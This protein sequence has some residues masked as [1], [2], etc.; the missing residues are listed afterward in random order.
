MNAGAAAELANRRVA[1]RMRIALP[2]TIAA[3]FAL[4]VLVARAP[5]QGATPAMQ[6]TAAGDLT[7]EEIF[8]DNVSDG[9][10]RALLSGADEAD[11]LLLI[12]AAEMQ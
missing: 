5:E 3:G 10:F 6:G 8:D 1:A 12:A 7:I 2:A 11:A 9:Q 4:F